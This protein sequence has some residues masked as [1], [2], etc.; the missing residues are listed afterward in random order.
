VEPVEA[1]KTVNLAVDSTRCRDAVCVTEEVSY[2]EGDLD[3]RHD[4]RADRG[5]GSP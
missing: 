4:A 2:Q 5:P 3:V 1:R